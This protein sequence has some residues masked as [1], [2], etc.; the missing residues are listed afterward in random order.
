MAEPIAA[1]QDGLLGQMRGMLSGDVDPDAMRLA[2]P[3]DPAKIEPPPGAKRR[4]G[5]RRS[6]RFG[7]RPA[8]LRSAN[9]PLEPALPHL[10]VAGLSDV[11]EKPVRLSFVSTERIRVP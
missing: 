1:Y 8:A 6:G 9:R 11:R 2:V 3:G 7:M 4:G 10:L 5:G